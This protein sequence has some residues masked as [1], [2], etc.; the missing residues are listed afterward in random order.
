MLF[1][2]KI[3]QKDSLIQLLQPMLQEIKQKII[4][5]TDLPP[6]Q[7]LYLHETKE[8]N[9]R[10]SCF[11][12][13]KKFL[14]TGGGYYEQMR[15]FN[16]ETYQ[17]INLSHICSYH[18][19]SANFDSSGKFL[20]LSLNEGTDI[21]ELPTLQKINSFSHRPGFVCLNFSEEY[22]VAYPGKMKTHIFSQYTNYTLEQLLLKKALLTWLLIEKP[23]KKIITL[24]NLLRDV[25]LKCDIPYDLSEI[26]STFPQNMQAALRRTMHDRIQKHGKD[27]NENCTIQ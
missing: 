19:Y 14:L 6:K 16:I 17:E 3:E 25:A 9:T 22:L 10:S 8:I 26:W 5:L 1:G 11:D 27:S 4:N 15:L 23:N 7:W 24:P 2:M 20:T 18:I 13:S 21:F 12:P